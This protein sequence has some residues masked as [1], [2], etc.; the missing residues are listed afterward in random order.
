[1]NN[2]NNS[3]LLKE[4]KSMSAPL[5]NDYKYNR[6]MP[7]FVKESISDEAIA[8]KQQFMTGFQKALISEDVVDWTCAMSAVR[9]FHR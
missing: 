2:N 8:W 3:S 5:A 4:Q 7:Q 6:F 1:M 9:I